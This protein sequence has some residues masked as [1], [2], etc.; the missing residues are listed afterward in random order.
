MCMCPYTSITERICYV[1]VSTAQK[2]ICLPYSKL[3]KYKFFA[4]KADFR[5]G[6]NDQ[7]FG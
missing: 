5:H 3:G 4:H 1:K 6:F 2:V 7:A